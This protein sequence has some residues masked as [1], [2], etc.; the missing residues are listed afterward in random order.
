MS[1]T[2]VIVP[3]ADEPRDDKPERPTPGQ[4][5]DA[6]GFF[7]IYKRGQGYWTRV[8]TT[9][10][11]VGVLL[12]T[13]HFLYQNL[14]VWL[15]TAKTTNSA[16]ATVEE[17][18]RGLALGMATGF[19]LV[20]LYIAYRVMNKPRNVDFLISTDGEMKKVNWAKWPEL[21]GSTRVVIIFMFFIAAL[22]FFI[23]TLFAFVFWL[24]SVLKVP[25]F[26]IQ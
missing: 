26:F 19:L 16:G 7:A 8:G 25:P 22:L 23:D 1:A 5:A 10:V 3:G 2:N 9:I 13:S 14:K 18:Q 4:T 21:F 20:T 11:T 6:G 15:P 24:T 12:L 17:V